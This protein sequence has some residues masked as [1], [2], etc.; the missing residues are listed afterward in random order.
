MGLISTIEFKLNS[1]QPSIQSPLSMPPHVID[2]SHWIQTKTISTIDLTFPPKQ[3]RLHLISSIHFKQT[4]LNPPFTLSPQAKHIPWNI[5]LN[6][7]LSMFDVNH[8][9][10]VNSSQPSTF[11]TCQIVWKPREAPFDPNHPIQTISS[12]PF[13]SFFPPNIGTFL[14][15]FFLS[16]L[17]HVRRYTS[18]PSKLPHL[19][20]KPLVIWFLFKHFTNDMQI[21]YLSW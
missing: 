5:L 2:L 21:G 17:Y 16:F 14:G 19:H 8:S 4:H 1:S 15:I 13:I 3:R 6:P 20:F 7:N 10:Q 9:F 12:Q 11:H 18:T